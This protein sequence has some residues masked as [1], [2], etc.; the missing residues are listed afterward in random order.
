[1]SERSKQEISEMVQETLEA[2]FPE[3][4][5]FAEEHGFNYRTLQAWK[6]GHRVPSTAARRQI[7]NLAEEHA[8]DLQSLA[9]SLRDAA[10]E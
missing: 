4:R 1:M 10:D 2:L 6:G 7:A 5:S 8:E 3:M 9:E